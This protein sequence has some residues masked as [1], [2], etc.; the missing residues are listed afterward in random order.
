MPRLAGL[1]VLVDPAACRGRDPVEIA[2]AALA[3][4]ASMLQWRD[5]L[6]DKGEQLAD[7]RVIWRL[8]TESD[9]TLIVNDHAD[10]AL[11]VAGVGAP[12]RGAIGVHVGQKDLPLEEVR[13][14]VPGHYVVGIS[15]NNAGEAWEGVANGAS[16]VACGDIFGTGSKTGTRPASLDRLAEVRAAVDLPVFGIG[17]INAGNAAQVMAAGASGVAVI[18]AVCSADDPEAAAR[19]LT[20]IVG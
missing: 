3:G 17:G 20:R 6:R 16:Y 7:V 13:R 10:L 5:K 18:S 11:V 8:C 15:T 1:Y 19:E 2:R 9:A 14:I 12:H 4:G